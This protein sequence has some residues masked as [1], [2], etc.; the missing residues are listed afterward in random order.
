MMMPACQ[1]HWDSVPEDASIEDVTAARKKYEQCARDEV[2][3][4]AEDT[5]NSE[6]E[7]RRT[8]DPEGTKRLPMQQ[9]QQQLASFMA[10]LSAITMG[11]LAFFWFISVRCLADLHGFSR[12]RARLVLACAGLLTTITWIFVSPLISRAMRPLTDILEHFL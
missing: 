11:V 12:W 4:C 5:G 3:R 10:L 9:Q 2:Q 8:L 6:D 7:C 1:H